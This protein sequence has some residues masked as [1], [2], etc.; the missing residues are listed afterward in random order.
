[1]SSEIDCSK[2][3]SV[4]IIHSQTAVTL[5]E[6]VYSD[7]PRPSDDRIFPPW[8][9]PV[10]LGDKIADEEQIFSDLIYKV[11][12][13]V[14]AGIFL[15]EDIPERRTYVQRLE[16]IIQEFEQRYREQL[17]KFDGYIRPFKE[18]ERAI[19]QE[20]PKP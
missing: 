11:G 15:L 9:D 19:L 13:L 8:I 20:F 6:V 14:M 5:L 16:K 7:K 12:E 10:F 18:F 2:I 17:A 4:I 1:M 3:H